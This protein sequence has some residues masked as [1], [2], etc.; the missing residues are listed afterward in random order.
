M[1]S[2]FKHTA[3]RALYG[4]KL[5][6][7]E[8]TRMFG[9]SFS[10]TR[11]A[12]NEIYRPRQPLCPIL[13]TANPDTH[14]ELT[15]ADVV[16]SDVQHIPSYIIIDVLEAMGHR[17]LHFVNNSIDSSETFYR[18][19]RDAYYEHI[20]GQIF[21][22]V[23]KDLQENKHLPDDGSSK[24]D[25]A[26]SGRIRELRVYLTSLHNVAT[27]PEVFNTEEW[28]DDDPAALV[29]LVW[30]GQQGVLLKFLQHFVQMLY[31]VFQ[32]NVLSRLDTVALLNVYV[33]YVLQD[34][35]T[36]NE[37]STQFYDVDHAPWEWCRVL[38]MQDFVEYATRENSL[39]HFFKT[40]VD[41]KDLPV[42]YAGLHA[43]QKLLAYR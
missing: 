16:N 23:E 31:T 30:L 3:K 12:A 13:D 42:K 32:Q 38:F 17:F 19:F 22:I 41:A 43:G 9:E 34:F 35:L 24:V 40:V 15:I 39:Q 7:Y 14:C 1:V 33:M 36:H 11:T 2:W 10:T 26:T 37:E 4:M 21:D 18:E 29:V 8:S 6:A 25:W 5:Q 28:H 20:Q 27:F